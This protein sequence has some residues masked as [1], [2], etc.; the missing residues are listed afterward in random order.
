V[1]LEEGG[2]FI[3]PAKLVEQTLRPIQEAGER[4]Y[5]AFVL[6]GGRLAPDGRRFEF[7]AAYCPQQTMSRGKKG[8]LVVVEG[9]ALHRVNQAFYEEG[10]TLAAQIHSHPQEAYHSETD[11]A[12]PMMTLRGGLSGVVPGFGA[13][14]SEGFDEW[15][16]Y[17]LRGPGW[18]QPLNQDTGMVLE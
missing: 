13:A 4:G 16:W 3:V 9:E 8:L 1:S 11:D 12:Y 7:A 10:L 2:E 5:E 17:R 18:W 15:V 14:G 6:W